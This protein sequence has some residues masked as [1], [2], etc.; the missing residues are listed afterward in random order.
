[1]KKLITFIFSIFS[2]LSF[3]QELVSTTPTMKNALIEEFT[4]A[5]CGNCPG[6][7]SIATVIENE[8]PGQ[9]ISIRYHH[10][11]LASPFGDGP[12]FRTNFS[13]AIALEANLIGQPLGIINRHLFSGQTDT[14]QPIGQ[15]EASCL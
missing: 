1:M 11:S 7:H 14:K 9:V 5:R 3:S 12:D 8:N 10:G 4:A 15:W 6:G 2:L 13:S